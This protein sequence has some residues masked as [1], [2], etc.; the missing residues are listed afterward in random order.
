MTGLL[1]EPGDAGALAE[2]IARLIENRELASDLGRAARQ[3]IQDRYSVER[4][5][6]ATEQLYLDL[7]ARRQQKTSLGFGHVFGRLSHR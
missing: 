3:A 1:V 4:M 6:R 7:L 2:S 5:V